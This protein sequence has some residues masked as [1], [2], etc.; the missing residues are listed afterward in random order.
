M[1][2]ARA[3]SARFLRLWA[4]ASQLLYYYLVRLYTGIS[5]GMTPESLVSWCQQRNGSSTPASNKSNGSIRNTKAS[6]DCIILVPSR[7]ST[8]P[9]KRCWQPCTSK[10]TDSPPKQI[11]RAKKN[12][13]VKRTELRRRSKV[14]QPL[15]ANSNRTFNVIRSRKC[16]TV[17]PL[18]MTYASRQ[19][20]PLW[21][22]QQS[23][24]W[25]GCE[26]QGL[27]PLLPLHALNGNK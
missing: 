17:T 8:R 18:P 21:T 10:R 27:R 22:N 20:V 24:S 7:V 6:P 4:G 15:L 2:L 25:S 26:L 13:R 1:A 12:K 19:I 16:H 3:E 14:S 23:F 5:R 9:G 11:Q